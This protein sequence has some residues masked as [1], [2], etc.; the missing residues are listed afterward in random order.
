MCKFDTIF[1]ILKI[2]SY[3][4]YYDDICLDICDILP[5]ELTVGFGSN[6]PN[7]KRLYL[8][9][10]EIGISMHVFSSMAICIYIT[11]MSSC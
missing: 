10:N 11:A 2:Y 5:T 9:T 6:M 7:L 4:I 3:K 8:G 1:D